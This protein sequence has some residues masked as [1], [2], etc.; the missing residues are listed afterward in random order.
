MLPTTWRLEKTVR[1]E[2]SFLTLDDEMKPSDHANIVCNVLQLRLILPEATAIGI[3]LRHVSR[4]S[5]GLGRRLSNTRII[6]PWVGNNLGKLSIIP[7]RPE[8]LERPQAKSS[9]AQG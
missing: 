6:C 5:S 2:L 3:R 1:R 4:E 8:M 7:H 9:G